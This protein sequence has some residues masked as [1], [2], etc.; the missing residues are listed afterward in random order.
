MDMQGKIVTVLSVYLKTGINQVS[1]N[2]AKLPDGNYMV[3]LIH[4]GE[5]R[6]QL[7]VILRR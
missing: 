4:Q 7:P 5:S 1:F 6:I 3:S 2:L